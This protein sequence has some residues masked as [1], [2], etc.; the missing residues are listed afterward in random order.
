MRESD[1]LIQKMVVI[2]NVILKND[3]LKRICFDE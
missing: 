3:S 1:V 2:N